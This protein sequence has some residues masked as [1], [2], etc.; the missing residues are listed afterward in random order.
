MF[1]LFLSFQIAYNLTLIVSYSW[2]QTTRGYYVPRLY[3]GIASQAMPFFLVANVLTGITNLSFQT[4]LMGPLPAAT[5][6]L[7]YTLTLT[8]A[9]SYLMKH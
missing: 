1:L 9:F 6:I 8:A 4:A 7:T 2:I 3:E 5:I